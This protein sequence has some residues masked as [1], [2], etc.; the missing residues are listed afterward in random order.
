V[1]DMQRMTYKSKISFFFSIDLHVFDDG[2]SSLIEFKSVTRDVRQH[3][4]LA[5]RRKCQGAILD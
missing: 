4:P 3:R 2:N 5:D 1:H